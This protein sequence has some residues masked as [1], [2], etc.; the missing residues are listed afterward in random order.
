MAPIDVL[1]FSAALLTTVSFLP[2]AIRVLKTRDTSALSL[3]MYSIFTV[4]VALWLCYGALKQDY[5]MI[6]ANGITLILATLIL[7]TKVHTE[8]FSRERHRTK[9]VDS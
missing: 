6:L 1:G 2:Q 7:A 9:K 4:G 5:A 3:A 8:Y